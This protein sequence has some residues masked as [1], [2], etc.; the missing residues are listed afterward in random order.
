M[1]VRDEVCG[2]EFE[3]SEAAAATRFEGKL[4]HFC[5]DRCKKLFREHPERYVPTDAGD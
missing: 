3:E 4:Y 1:Q 2:M 5:A